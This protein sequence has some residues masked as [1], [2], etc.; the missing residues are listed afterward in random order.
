M[1]HKSSLPREIQTSSIVSA[2][3]VPEQLEFD[4]HDPWADFTEIAIPLI[5]FCLPVKG[6]WLIRIIQ[7]S[8]VSLLPLNPSWRAILGVRTAVHCCRS[9][10]EP[11]RTKSVCRRFL[12]PQQHRTIS[13]HPL[14]GMLLDR[15]DEDCAAA[16]TR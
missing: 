6:T 3:G 5:D 1:V 8:V 7:G 9:W 4:F 13:A 16:S 10:T 15:P 2:L 12:V 14:A 11:V